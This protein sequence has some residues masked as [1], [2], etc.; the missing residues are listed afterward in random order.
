MGTGPGAVAHGGQLGRKGLATGHHPQQDQAHQYRGERYESLEHVFWPVGGVENG[1]D[2]AENG[3]ELVPI[4]STG[5]LYPGLRTI[6]RPRMER[7][8]TEARKVPRSVPV[9]LLLP[10]RRR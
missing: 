8:V 1:G 9:I 3:P 4:R 6:H 2:L 10:I 5:K 7:I